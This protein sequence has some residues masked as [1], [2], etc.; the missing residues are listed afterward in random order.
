M[1][2]T[3]I[4]D[5]FANDISR[6]IEEVIKVDQTDEQLIREELAEYVVTDSIRSHLTEVLEAYWETPKKPH[7]GIGVWVSGFFGSGKSSFAKY[8]GLALE[9]RSIVGETAGRLL[10]KR[11]GDS[12]V[13]VLLSN[14]AEQIPTEA[15]IF[16]VS[17]DRGIRTGNQ[18]ITE[19]MYRLFL[20]SLGYARDLD[21]SEL[22]ITLE[23]AGRLDEFKVKYQEV[24]DKDWN[25][26]KGLIAIAVQQASRVMHELEPATYTTADSWRESAMQR[27]DITPRTLADRA[28]ELMTRRHPGKALIFVID[29]VGQ[30]VARDSQKMEDL[31][32]V[33]QSLGRAGRG[34]L[35]IVATSQEKLN[36]LV[37]GL[38]DR[39]IELAKLM[40]RFPLQVHL[41]PADISEVTSKRVLSK[42][43]QAERLLRELFTQHRGR[44]TDNTRLTADIK[45]PELS[46]E[47]FVDLYPLLPYQID[48][49]IQVVSGLRTEGGASK[50][51]GGAARTIIK[52][53][54]QL[55]IHP[56]VDLASAPLGALARVDQV[57]DLVSGNIASEVRGKVDDIG[58]KV[59]HPLAQPVAKAICL[60]Q[61]VRSIHRTPEN[62]AA[63]LHPALDADSRLSEVKA[64]LG[65][66]ERAHMVRRGDDGYRIP[67]PAE[68]DWE[69][70][71]ASLSP[72][73]G[74]ISRLHAEIVTSLWQPQPHHSFLDVKVFKAGLYLGG[75]VS[76][77]GDIAVHLVLA[78]AGQEHKERL[79]ESRK[80]S[81]TESKSVF[82]V[83]AVDEA[84]D[85]ETVELFRSK[86]ILSRK[87]R[88]ARTKDET[89]LVAEEKLRLRLH[90]DELRRL[91]KQSLLTGTIHFR[92]NDRSPDDTA[93]D[94]GRTAAKVLAQALPE[95]FDRFEEAAA[96]VGKKDLE[97]L[98][99][100]ENLRGLTSVFTHLNLVRDQGGKP[101]LNTESGPLA[102]VLS[103]IENRTSYGEVATGRYLTDEFAKE[104]FGWD[105]DVIRLFVIALLR[106]GKLEATSKGQVIES[107]MSL[108]ARNTFANNNLFRQASFRPKVG[109][110]FTN[111]VDASEYF[112]EVFGR[113][114]SE[115]EQGVVANAIREEIHRRDEE[116]HEVHTTLVQHGL[117]GADVLRTALD[118]MRSIR[119]GNE[120]HAVLTFNS[121]YKE[122][123]EAIKRGA[124]LAQ[125]LTEPRL[126]DITRARKALDVIWPFLKE[127]PD[128][129][130][131][132]REHAGELEDLMARE[133]F[134]RELAA[135]D[136][137]ARALEREH[138]RRHQEA[139]E[140]RAAAYEEAAKKLKATPGWEQLAEDQQRRVAGPLVSRATTDGT[141]SMA[142]PL[143]RS[144]LD[145]CS[146]RLSSAVEEM[147]R[148]VDGNRVVRVAASSYFSG[149]I[150]TEEQLDQALSGLKEQCLELIGAGKKVLVQ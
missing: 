131:E 119:A 31:R 85:R 96:R 52:L 122:L 30:F 149:G 41:E 26:G 51:V 107:A 113:E 45:L 126:D 109:L 103:R 116:L 132:D 123:K 73:P 104:P 6:R 133:T 64:A 5:L 97:S 76:V 117:P 53:A 50:H 95:V 84:I 88:G 138:E 42:N 90:Q 142:I 56:N 147:L 60:L 100:T 40:D 7:E 28:L 68:D 141:A 18:T 55:L 27:A 94:V 47:S 49:V 98:M 67:T 63:A 144:D 125:V 33:V 46:T 82:W 35:W 121:A 44:L 12:K 48:L 112:K 93:I 140:A 146:G 34:K 2:S 145:A 134:F 83:A 130:D 78:E 143:L 127:E 43:A 15:V 29:E 71:R 23:E 80:R 72:K 120:D 61:Y 114:I 77:D 32:S 148:L 91:I 150:E 1:T 108:D 10:A 128:L 8:L 21:L 139:A 115:L 16:D 57:Y 65:A 37:S 19:I 58:K 38:D 137:H 36:E 101:V 99:T 4:K 54:Q 106:A 89:A 39:R 79:A 3:T 11:A 105:F 124:E 17:T 13:E 14:I 136:Q 86:E 69:R 70:Q 22:E 62:L 25:V 129:T 81:Q 111:I 66:L 110:E 20:Q 92:G 74:D 87:E 102:E 9:N 24:F 118:Q 59:D 75:R 135:I